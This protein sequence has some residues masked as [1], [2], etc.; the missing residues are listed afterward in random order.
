MAEEKRT[1]MMDGMEP[2]TPMGLVIAMLILLRG[3]P[4]DVAKQVASKKIDEFKAWLE[5]KGKG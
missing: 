2:I 4:W 1:P 5:R 3:I